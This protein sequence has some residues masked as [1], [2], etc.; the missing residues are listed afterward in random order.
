MNKFMTTKVSCFARAY[1]FENNDVHIFADSMAKRILGDDYGQIAESMMQGISFFLPKFEGTREEGLRL[2]VDKQL[3]PSVLGR[4]AFCEKKLMC[5]VEQGCSQYLIFA[6]GYDTFSLRTEDASIFVYELDLPEMLDDKKKRIDHAGL[7]SKAKNVKC[8]LADESWAEKLLE[9]GFK[10][11]DKSFGSLLGISYYLEKDEWRKLL[12]QIAT[13]IP[14][15]SAVCF[16]FPS[17][18]ESKETKVNNALAS[19]AGEPMKARYTYEDMETLLSE[20][21]FCVTEHLGPKEM[22][23]QY[24][25]EYNRNTSAHTMEAPAGVD[26]VFAVRE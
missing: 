6:S 3:S 18:D 9:Q 19:G 8:D 4:S 25:A 5:E 2:I 12:E 11:S 26:Y 13:I 24:F 20:C 23:E 15:G 10:A 1:H 7:K 14:A 17:A 22:T 16:D 21:G